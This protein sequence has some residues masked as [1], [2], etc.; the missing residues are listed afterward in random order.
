MFW[1]RFKDLCEKDGTKPNPVA[2][3]LGISSGAVT[4]WKKTGITPNGSTLQLI[5][6]RF[7]VSVD[8]LIGKTDDPSPQQK[9]PAAISDELWEAMQN[10]PR[11]VALLEL[12]LKMSPEQMDAIEKAIGREEK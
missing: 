8:Y 12:L 7:D 5:A 2:A 6:E 4:K 10:N 1:D 11:A 3:Q 9:K